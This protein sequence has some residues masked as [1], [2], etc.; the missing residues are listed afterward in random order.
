[1]LVKHLALIV[2]A[3]IALV[4]GGTVAA[5]LAYGSPAARIKP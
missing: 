3:P 5:A 4:I 2:A 1:L